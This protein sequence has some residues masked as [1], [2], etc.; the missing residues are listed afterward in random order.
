MLYVPDQPNRYMHQNAPN[1]KSPTDRGLK[2]KELQL[3]SADGTRLHGW[4]I[5]SPNGGKESRTIV[6]MHENAGN[7]GHRL[8]YLQKMVQTLGYNVI[9]VSYRGYGMSQGKP[10]EQGIQ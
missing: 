8:D 7:I 3:K 1:Y 10:T 6:Y 5:L 9:V 4:L 2:H